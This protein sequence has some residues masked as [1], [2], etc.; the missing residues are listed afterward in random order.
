MESHKIVYDFMENYSLI[1]K[2]ATKQCEKCHLFLIILKNNNKITTTT[3]NRI[4]KKSSK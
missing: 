4:Q 2:N 3:Q 1:S